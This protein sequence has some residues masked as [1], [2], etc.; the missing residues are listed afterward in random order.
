MKIRLSPFGAR[1]IEHIAKSDEAS[2]DE[3]TV[4]LLKPSPP[5]CVGDI[6]CDLLGICVPDLGSVWW[7]G[8]R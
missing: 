7:S 5:A 8:E 2:I 4:I 1:M 3:N 6:G